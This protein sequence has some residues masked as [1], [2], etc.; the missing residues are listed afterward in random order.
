MEW[1]PLLSTVVE[2]VSAITAGLL[3]FFVDSGD[4]LTGRAAP[5]WDE[6][7]RGD[8]GGLEQ[9]ITEQQ[10]SDRECSTRNN[11]GAM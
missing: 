9:E 8:A 4:I 3:Y 2:N 1:L 7:A 6:R 11:R 5:G 10:I